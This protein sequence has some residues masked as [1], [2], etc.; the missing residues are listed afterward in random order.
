MSGQIVFVWPSQTVES[1]PPYLDSLADHPHS[2]SL[3]AYSFLLHLAALSSFMLS[4][5]ILCSRTHRL[6]CGYES[7]FL[8]QRLKAL[9]EP[10]KLL[11]IARTVESMSYVNTKLVEQKPVWAMMTVKNAKTG[12]VGCAMS[13]YVEFKFLAR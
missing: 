10:I 2:S 1:L 3:T 7:L 9:G 5:S 11:H 8:L 13:I 4:S 6:N 12:E